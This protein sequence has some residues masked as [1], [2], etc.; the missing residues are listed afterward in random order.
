MRISIV[1][2]FPE[3]FDSPLSVSIVGRAVD[4]GLVEID[5]VDLRSH[6]LGPH[7]QV[8]DAPFGGGPGMV[9][10]IGPLAAALDPFES[11]HRVLLT[12]GGSRLS[13]DHLDRWADVEHLTLVCGRFEGV[14]E[15]VAERLIDEQV[16]LGDFVIAGGEAVA[17]AIVEGVTRL[18]PGVVGNP[19]SIERESFR[20]GLLEEPQYTRPS[21]FRGWTVPEILLS[22]DHARIGEWRRSQQLA[23]TRQR[24]PD[25][26]AEFVAASGDEYDPAAPDGRPCSS[27]GTP[28]EHA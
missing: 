15:R 24:R 14:D 26:F 13:Q 9:M 20:E 3:F 7:R 1:T 23:R 22:G 25:L 16:S 21:E 18:L 27:E 11:S 4:A 10:M 17:T 28:D 19:E 6:G 8:D 12:P 5:L 2:L